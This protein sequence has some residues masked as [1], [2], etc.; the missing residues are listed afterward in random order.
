MSLKKELTIEEQLIIFKNG[1]TAV[2][3]D[4]PCV[5]GDGIQNQNRILNEDNLIEYK[6]LITNKECVKFVP[7]SGAATR[8]FKD[9]VILKN[10]V[11]YPSI[12][13]LETSDLSSRDDL[14]Y[15][16]NNLKHLPFYKKVKKKLGSDVKLKKL[17]KTTD[18]SEIIDVILGEDQL[19]YL[20]KPKALIPFHNYFGVTRTPIYEH[21]QE[22]KE[23][24]LNNGKLSVHFTVSSNHMKK[25]QKKL[26]KISKNEVFAINWSLSNQD[27]RTDTIAVDKDNNPVLDDYGKILTRPG[28]HGALIFNLNELEYD[29]AHIKNIDNVITVPNNRNSNKFKQF[30]LGYF[31]SIQKQLF[32]FA[33]RLDNDK[34]DKSLTK[35]IARFYQ[36]E[37]FLKIDK[38]EDLKKLLNRPLRV[39]AM[40]RNEDQPGGGPFFVN[41]NG[42]ITTQIVE[43]AQIDFSIGKN[44]SYFNKSTHFNPVDMICGLTDYKGDKYNLLDFVNSNSY[45]ITNKT[46]DGQEIKALE[47]PGLWNGGMYD[48]NT[49]FIEMPE[50]YFN[51]V[52]TVFDLLDRRRIIKK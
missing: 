22:S 28:G 3:L 47:L 6:N 31:Y 48:W 39:C 2:V 24:L 46:H 25:I 49:I 51:P 4:K 11:K 50:E 16:F 23:Y 29:V 5:L 15:L 41:D 27:S 45:F 32:N 40:V 33:Q 1:T 36:D 20:N 34:E 12:D 13:Y 37:F 21:I 42:N 10:T 19:D 9:L 7:A 18:L 35:E 38:N 26:K 52:K 8:M 43:A 17:D 14:L 44:E 30:M